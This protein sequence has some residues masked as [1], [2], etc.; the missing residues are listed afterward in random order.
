MNFITKFIGHIF[1]VLFTVALV[2][3]ISCD[4]YASKE[5]DISS[6]DAKA[7][8][9]LSD[10]LS[11]T[12]AAVLLTQFNPEWLDSIVYD[13][14]LNKYNFVSQILDSL[15]AHGLTLTDSPQKFRLVTLSSKN[16]CYYSLN[17]NA[18]QLVF[19]ADAN[20]DINIIE[21]DGTI[22]TSGNPTIPLETTGD[23]VQFDEDLKRDVPL[24]QARISFGIPENRTLLKIIKNEQ[25]GGS[26]FNVAIM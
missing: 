3:F 19:F 1:C 17:T 13:V 6:L 21:A 18:G 26:V 16:E 20:I 10:T 5:F 23:C 15:D 7:C 9:A 2:L 4:E 11:D 24:I 25:T 12:R 8:D 22:L 14:N